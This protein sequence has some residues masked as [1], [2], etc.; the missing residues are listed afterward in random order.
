MTTSNKKRHLQ[1]G[2]PFGTAQGRLRKM[3]MFQMIQKLGL[4]ICFQCGKKIETVEELSIEHKIPWLDKENA[5][6]LFWDLDNIAF[7]HLNCNVSAG[8]RH[9]KGDIKHPSITSYQRGC[10]CLECVEQKRLEISRYRAKKKID[11]PMYRRKVAR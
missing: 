5:K 7:S 8:R 3:I 6:E 10:R 2:M 9:N 4:D 11:N 1:L